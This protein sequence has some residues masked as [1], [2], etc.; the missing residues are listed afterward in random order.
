MLYGGRC[1]TWT[2]LMEQVIITIKAGWHELVGLNCFLFGCEG[3][4][5][6]HQY[7][8]LPGLNISQ[9]TMR[10]PVFGYFC[11]FFVQFQAL[12]ALHYSGTQLF[13]STS[14]WALLDEI[15]SS[16][17]KFYYSSPDQISLASDYRTSVNSEPCCI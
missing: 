7:C 14:P 13:P 17:S 12:Q 2:H 16:S 8:W 3:S 9:L 1:V 10:A 11:F 4:V 6:C 5:L 15:L